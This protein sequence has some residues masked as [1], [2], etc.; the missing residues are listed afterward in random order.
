MQTGW[1]LGLANLA[2]C[3]LLTQLGA[4]MVVGRTR[5][6]GGGHG[7]G[8]APKVLAGCDSRWQ[9]PEIVTSDARLSG[10]PFVIHSPGG[11]CMSTWPGVVHE[12][13]GSG[14]MGAGEPAGYRRQGHTTGQGP[15]AGDQQA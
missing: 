3:G 9:K 12:H 5:E 7:H 13:G 10:L 11:A 2:V 6:R 8:S 14:A 15:A 1:A 4:T